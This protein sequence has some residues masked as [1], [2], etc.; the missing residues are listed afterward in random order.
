MLTLLGT[1]L[2]LDEKVAIKLSCSSVESSHLLGVDAVVQKLFNEGCCPGITQMRWVGQSGKYQAIVS[3]PLGP[4]L[5]DLFN[6]CGRKFSLKTILL[7]ADQVLA[8][9]LSIDSFQ[10]LHRDIKPEHLLMGVGRQENVIHVVGF[11]AAKEFDYDE[12]FDADDDTLMAKVDDTPM[13]PRRGTHLFASISSHEGKG[14]LS[15]F[16]TYV[17][18]LT[19]TRTDIPR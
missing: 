16:H 10:Y 17:N 1:D 12:A 5:E 14:E 18:L 8:R 11:G 15:T 19:W 3:D 9:L 4:S 2:E 13:A 6:L 7:I